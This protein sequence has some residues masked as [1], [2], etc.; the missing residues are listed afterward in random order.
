MVEV[1]GTITTYNDIIDARYNPQGFIGRKWL[2]KEVTRFRDGKGR[3]SLIIVGEPGSGKSTF[4]AYLAKLWNCPRHFIRVGNIGGVTGVDPRAFLVSLGSQLYQKYGPHIFEQSLSG[5]VKVAVGWAKDQTEVVGRFVEELYR[6][7]FLPA[8]QDDV[9]VQVGVATGHSQVIGERIERLVDVTLK[10]DVLTLLHVALINP[11]QKIQVLYP[12]EKVLIFIDALDESLYHP[13]IKILDILP[14][15]FDAEFPANLRLVMTS[16]PSESLD[17]FRREDQLKLDDEEKGYKNE[18]LRDIRVYINDRLDNA[19]FDKLTRYWSQSNRKAYQHEVEEKSDGN[20]LYLYYLF[21]EL[22][23]AVEAGLTDMHTFEIP[24]GL[25]EIYRSFAVE[26]IRQN[27]PDVIRFTIVEKPATIFY[28]QLRT[29]PGVSQTEISGQDVLLTTVNRNQLIPMLFSSS[30]QIDNRTFQFQPGKQLGVWEEKYLPILGVMAVAQ[31]PLHRKQIAGFAKVEVI[32]VDSVLMQLKQFL[33]E[34]VYEQANAYQFYHTSFSEYLVDSQQNRDYPLDASA[35]HYQIAS[36]YRGEST[37]WDEV[38]WSTI[39]DSYPF[40]HLVAHLAASEHSEEV[41]RLLAS[42]TKQQRNTWFEVKEARNDT[43]GYLADVNRAWKLAETTYLPTDPAHTGQTIG[44]QC[45]YALINASFISKARYIHPLLVRAK[46]EKKEWTPAQGLVYVRGTPGSS[47]GVKGLASVVPFLKEPLKTKVLE[48]VLEIIQG[49][50][51]EGR[52]I[53]GRIV[54][55]SFYDYSETIASLAPFLSG[56]L[57]QKAVKMAQAEEPEVRVLKVLAALAPFLPEGQKV[58]ILQQAIE[59]TKKWYKQTYPDSISGTSPKQILN[60]KRQSPKIFSVLSEELF[61]KAIK[62]AQ[63]FQSEADRTE[64]LAAQTSPLPDGQKMLMLQ[65]VLDAR[66]KVL[67]ITSA[68]K[69]YSSIMAQAQLIPFL[70]EKIKEKV[71][72]ETLEEMKTTQDYVQVYVLPALA[73][74]L[75]GEQLREAVEM[76]WAIKDKAKRATGLLALAPFLPESL[77]RDV[78]KTIQMAEDDFG[79]VETLVALTFFMPENLRE[80]ILLEALEA[81]LV[82]ENTPI[83]AKVLNRLISSLPK[84]LEGEAVLKVLRAAWTIR[85]DA[86][87]G[88]VLIKL[89]PSLSESLV[90]EAFENVRMMSNEKSR[91]KALAGLA[92]SLSKPLLQEAWK[93]AQVMRFENCRVEVLREL[94]PFLSKLQLQ[95]AWKMVQAKQFEAY[96]V[97]VLLILSPFFPEE[98]R[99]VMLQEAMGNIVSVR[100]ELLKSLLIPLSPLSEPLQRKALESVRAHLFSS[101]IVGAQKFIALLPFLSKQLRQEALKIAQTMPDEGDRAEVLLAVASSLSESSQRETSESS[102]RETIEVAKRR[103][104]REY[105]ERKI[106]ESSQR[107]A[108]EVIK[109]KIKA[110]RMII[111]D[112]YPA[113]ELAELLPTL[114]QTLKEEV[115]QEIIKLVDRGTGPD[116]YMYGP[117]RDEILANIAPFLSKLQLQEVLQVVRTMKNEYDHIQALF[118]LASSLPQELKEE[119]LQETVEAL[120]KSALEYPHIQMLKQLVPYLLSEPLLRSA[121]QVTVA[122]VQEDLRE[123]ILSVLVS[124][125]TKFSPITLYP[126]WIDLIHKI[127]NNALKWL[128]SDI[129]SISPCIFALGGTEAAVETCHALLY[130]NY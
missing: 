130:V 108:I 101:Y 99:E 86:L 79:W 107:E 97:E 24:K 75:S 92:S 63:K 81:I 12:T 48:E 37:S 51:V 94:A 66:L 72:R 23:S 38:A 68:T 33:D 46:L 47:V 29:M 114:P 85:D 14:Q 8:Q 16:R 102:Q 50:V 126:I 74:S 115:L 96:R 118:A 128:L 111:R 53:R 4:L 106:A 82:F 36:Y 60:Y 71:T 19:P 21:E 42:G 59:A 110:A 2:I 40:N 55:G 80:K 113:G 45:R 123:E 90:L 87:R 15:D 30:F 65:Q 76:A 26:K 44:L 84:K 22:A 64:R 89:G 35:Y 39:E 105:M 9:Q 129:K 67:D 61:E 17:K 32:Y 34:V 41:H 122:I 121:L 127:S 77:L 13:G 124:H 43:A 31:E 49:R 125:L 83:R 27:V 11:L 112:E 116:V 52:I 91:A 28:D 25:D 10:L 18:N 62:I 103:V 98:Q 56:T 5:S 3:R 73:P 6:L 88:E 57:L 100:E 20:F 78:L 70:P 69:H 119:V 7:P 1:F 120:Y 104:Y 58:E 93:M 95:E 117:Y 109:K 54:R